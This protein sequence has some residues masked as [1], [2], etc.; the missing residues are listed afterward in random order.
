V[1][2]LIEYLTKFSLKIHLNKKNVYKEF[3]HALDIVGKSF[4]SKI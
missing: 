3:E 2:K 4:V 1:E